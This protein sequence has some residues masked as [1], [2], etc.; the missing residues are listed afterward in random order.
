VDEGIE[1]GEIDP[2]ER[3]PHREP[4]AL[5]PRRGIG[6]L[7]DRAL[8]GLVGQPRQPGELGGVLDG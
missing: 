8:A 5:E 3:P 6:D 4:F 1:V 2:G 7:S